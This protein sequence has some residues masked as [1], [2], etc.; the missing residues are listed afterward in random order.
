MNQGLIFYPMIILSIPTRINGSALD[1]GA[2]KNQRF[3]LNSLLFFVNM[4]KFL[5]DQR[6][7]F[8]TVVALSL[9]KSLYDSNYNSR[10]HN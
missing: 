10:P 7:K 3:K 9:I 1:I 4:S 2:H 6:L 8:V 5:N